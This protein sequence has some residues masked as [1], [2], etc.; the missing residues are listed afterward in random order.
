MLRMV[1]K[2]DSNEPTVKLEYIIKDIFSTSWL[3]FLAERSI[4]LV[5]HVNCMPTFINLFLYHYYLGARLKA[6][7]HYFETGGYDV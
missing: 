2:N 3:S 6:A 7:E 1:L 4:A 5:F